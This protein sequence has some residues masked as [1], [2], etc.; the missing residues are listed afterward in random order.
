M[1]LGKSDKTLLGVVFIILVDTVEVFEVKFKDCFEC[2]IHSKW[3]ENRDNY[4]MLFFLFFFFLLNHV[5][6]T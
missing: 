6:Q 1:G 5:K 2:R 3:E 4:K